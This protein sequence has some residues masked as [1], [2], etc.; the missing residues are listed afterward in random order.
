MLNRRQL[1]LAGATGVVL[2][3]QSPLEKVE[4]RAGNGG[5]RRLSLGLSGVAYYIGFC[6]FLNWQ[7]MANT[8]VLSRRGKENIFGKAAFDA[9]YFN[10]DTGELANPA[11]PDLQA[12]VCIFYAAPGG[13]YIAGGFDFSGMRWTI[14]WVG[15]AVCVINGLTRGGSQSINNAQRFGT[16]T[17]GTNPGNTWT[18][19]TLTDRRD[20]PRN[21]RIY[22]SRYAANVA[23]GETF[24][25]DW[26]SQIRAFGVLRLMGWMSTN[27]N[28]TTD[29]AQIADE[30]YFRWGSALTETSEFGPKGGAPLSLL[31]KLANLTRCNIHVNIPHRATDSFVKSFAGYFRDHLDAGI[32]VTFEYSNECWNFSF[33]QARYCLAQGS[34][35]WSI[36]D[37]ARYAKWYGYRSAQCMKIIADTFNNRSRWRGCL[38]TQTVNTDVTTNAT[39]PGRSFPNSTPG[40]C[41]I[42]DDLRS[43]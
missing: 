38:A 1:L 8:P 36:A 5:K 33:E 40:C 31:C 28:A 32:I 37:G 10:P 17:F 22:Q 6:P 13:G 25:P 35:I 41:E 9:G 43:F 12:V 15:S 26:L 18:T 21:I 29:F 24:N 16:F 34:A 20:P 19:F 39:H 30:N 11:L 23:A 7:K 4:D 3:A 2:T 14:E 27:G 42:M